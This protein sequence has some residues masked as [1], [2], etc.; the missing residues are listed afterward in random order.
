MSKAPLMRPVLIDNPITLYRGTETRIVHNV[1][2]WDEA[3][4]AGFDNYTHQEYPKT[5]YSTA[6]DLIVDSADEEKDALANGYQATPVQAKP[7]TGEKKAESGAIENEEAAFIHNRID[8]IE[9]KLDDLIALQTK[10][11]NR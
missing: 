6:G 8:G 7:D 4:K 10:K 2:Q 3:V 11:S 1:K 5:V 9:K